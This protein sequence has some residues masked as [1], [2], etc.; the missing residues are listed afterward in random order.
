M[1]ELNLLSSEVEEDLRG[2]VRALLDN[3][4]THDALTGLSDGQPGPVGLWKSMAVD[5]GLAGLLIPEDLGGAGTSGREAAVVSE[6]V[7]R[8]VA[9]VP[10]LTSAVIATTMLGGRADELLTA[11]AAGERTAAVVVPLA[12]DPYGE[13]PTVSLHGEKLDGQVR[14]VAGAIDA[15]LLLVPAGTGDR[16]EIR[17]VE[18]GHATV[19]PVT[20][21]DMTRQVADVGF[22]TSASTQVIGPGEAETALRQGLV[23]GAAMLASEQLGLARRSFEQTLEYL[24]DRHQFGRV[25]GGFQALKHRFADLY[26]EVESAQA[27]AR[28]AAAALADDESEIEVATA[29]AQSYCSDVCVHVVEDCLQLYGGIAMTWEHPIHL[30]LKR[31]KADQIALGTPATHR[32]RLGQ[33]VD[34]PA[35]TAGRG[36]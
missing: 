31:A 34:L 21:L 5:L 22:E 1:S 33:L 6:E 29:T 13:L 26:I 10:Y 14:S 19:T 4:C 25:V 23:A 30:Y 7:G 12:T 18:A 27:V 17:A 16:I 24:K 32:R 2:S 8:A 11:L 9:P 3:T 36:G 35:P 20:S 15:D 28:H